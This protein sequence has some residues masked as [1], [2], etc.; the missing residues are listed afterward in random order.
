M[1]RRDFLK[2]AGLGALVILPWGEK[3]LALG[4][5]RPKDIL[6]EGFLEPPAEARPFYRWWWNG[7]RVTDEE[8]RRELRLMR[9]SG[10]GG[11]EINPIASPATIENPTGRAL[12]WLSPRWCARIET[13]A[14]EGKKLGL[15]ID[16]IVGTGW[17][18]GGEFLKPHETIQG[19]QLEVKPLSGPGEY[20]GRLPS[21]QGE[22]EKLLQ[23]KLLPR[24]ISS[25]QEGR[26]MLERVQPD[27][28]ISFPIPKGEWD[29][30]ILKWRSRFR[31]VHRGAPGGAG[32]VLDHFNREAVE[33]YLNQ[34][35]GA[36]KAELGPDIGRWIRAMFCDSIELAG[37]NWTTDLPEEFEK[38]RDYELLPYLPL[39]LNPEI[40][41]RDQ[42]AQTLRKVRYDYSLTL[43][44]MFME[45]FIIPYHEWCHRIGTRSRYQ[46]YGAPWLYTDLLEGYLVPDI[47]EADQWLFNVGWMKNVALDDIRYAVWNKYAAAGGR[48][49]GKRIISTEAMT[50]TKGVFEASLEY[51]KQA[52]DINIIMGI[53]HLV[54]HGYNY[55]PPEAGFP[56]WV[57]FGTYFNEHNPWFPYLRLWADYAARLCW[58]FQESE[59]T[60]QVAIMGPTADIWSNKGL[61][62]NP[63]IL[64]PWY[65]HELWQALSHHGYYADYINP[66]ILQGARFEGGAIL[67]GSMAY[68]ILIVAGA[69]SLE[70]ETAAAVLRY[71]E[72]GGKVVFVGR[73]PHRSPGM[74]RYEEK[75]EKVYTA[76]QTALDRYPERVRVVEEPPRSGLVPWAGELMAAF[77]AAPAVKISNPDP[78]LFT[79]KQVAGKREIYF[80]SNM[81]RDREIPFSA[82]FS[83]KGKT[84]W[85]W[86]PETGR[87]EM[88]P[89]GKIPESLDIRLGPLESL[90]LVFEPGRAR[91]KPPIPGTITDSREVVAITGPW[92]VALYPVVGEPSQIVLPQLTDL[93]QHPN[94][95]D[96]SGAAVY[97]TDLQLNE[98]D[99]LCLD[100]GRVYETA[101]VTLNGK[102]LGVK[103]WGR[104]QYK[105]DGAVRTGTNRLEIKVTTLLFNTCRS[106]KDNPVAQFW[107]NRSATRQPRPA[108]LV[109]PVRL[110]PAVRVTL[111]GA[112]DW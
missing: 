36:L 3:A 107:T 79:I 109:G 56:G 57:Q 61:V 34:M 49:T 33:K 15:I 47:P 22:N 16:L 40:R 102:N 26:D 52:T 12:E 66:T 6:Y 84:P 59:P 17:P 86:D 20:R 35:S 37:A 85:R 30:Y 93:A 1:D 64:T 88:Y 5:K 48:L 27:G 103:W 45:R 105:L 42:L 60:A 38:R 77:D 111:P 63:W 43:A 89:Y 10:A 39:V 44:E 106:L 13:A 62:R 110:V 96:F 73:S 41:A 18:F 50:N 91:K 90:L 67:Y 46:A 58:I 32:P 2:R 92:Q 14:A 74:A 4:G 31:E 101:E 11:A 100:L 82:R 25:L 28:T 51:I 9:D 68:D 21:L 23:L 98:K 53:N 71:A 97:S 72:Q 69:E 7:N 54:L 95:E 94:L 70:P 55:S 19:L 81:D 87:R 78:K 24:T 83:A 104:R 65:L 75:C 29:L 99:G 8:I 108:G 112:G 80:F 76:I